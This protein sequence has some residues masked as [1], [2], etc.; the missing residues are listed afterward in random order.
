MFPLGYV[1]PLVRLSTKL[2]FL[3][4]QKKGFVKDGTFTKFI[5]MEIVNSTALL[6][7]SCFSYYPK[8][9]KVK[10]IVLFEL[11]SHF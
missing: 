9:V 7:N 5:Y 4:V 10:P 3:Q 2:L 1:V 8:L 6:G 11:V